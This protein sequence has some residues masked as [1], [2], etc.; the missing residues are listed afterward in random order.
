M[1]KGLQWSNVGAFGGPDPVKGARGIVRGVAGARI[2][3][4]SFPLFLPSFL[5]YW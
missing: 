4:R 2:L 3:S 5:P 1:Y